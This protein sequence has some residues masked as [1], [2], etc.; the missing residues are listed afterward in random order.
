MK[1]NL[2]ILHEVPDL[3]ELSARHQDFDALMDAVTDEKIRKRKKFY[4]AGSFV[5][6]IMATVFLSW[7]YWGYEPAGM[8]E[9]VKQQASVPPPAKEK[10]MPVEEKEPTPEVTAVPDPVVEAPGEKEEVVKTEPIVMQSTPEEAEK[11]EEEMASPQVI[12]RE[13]VTADATPLDG[14]ENLYRYLYQEIELPDSMLESDE[15]FF[16]EVE[17]E[18]GAAGEI[19]AVSFNKELPAE[20][21]TRLSKVFLEMPAWKP[22]LELGDSIAS[23]INLPITFQKKGGK[24]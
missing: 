5:L 18:I 1:T 9:A 11:E 13:K 10:V 6:V 21:E 20:L 8:E 12:I 15:T 22:A 17:F 7:L 4:K 19:G 16:M 23:V 24:R 3:D 2:K 14:L